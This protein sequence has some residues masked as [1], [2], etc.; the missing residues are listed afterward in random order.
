MT[1]DSLNPVHKYRYQV[2]SNGLGSKKSWV[3]KT[4]PPTQ[5]ASPPAR[6]FYKGLKQSCSFPGI[7]IPGPTPSGEAV[8]FTVSQ[9][10]DKGQ[11]H[12][13]ISPRRDI[14]GHLVPTDLGPFRPSQAV[15]TT[16]QPC[17]RGGRDGEDGS[18]PV[19]PSPR[20]DSASLQVTENSVSERS[21]VTHLSSAVSE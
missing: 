1:K 12:R 7:Q 17:C 2:S 15:H 3:I 6:S 13:A 21:L 9:T 8:C 16:Q 11:V 4:Q 20:G 18:R 10:E 5:G 14:T 19:L